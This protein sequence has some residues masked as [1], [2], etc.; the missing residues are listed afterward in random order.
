MAARFLVY[1]WGTKDN[2]FIKIGHCQGN[3]YKRRK[4]IQTGCPL[5]INEYPNGVIVCQGKDE[6]LRVEKASQKQFKAYRTHGEWFNLTPEI[7]EYIVKVAD[8][9][10]GKVF[11]ENGRQAENRYLCE[12]RKNPENR[13]AQRQY[14][15]EWQREK[16]DNDPEWREARREYKREYDARR[17]QGQ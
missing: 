2:Q 14:K 3:L 12:W 11:M 1:F 9:K 15:R 16:L 8:T 4:A 17:K 5:P 13:E 7:S 10:S 6:M